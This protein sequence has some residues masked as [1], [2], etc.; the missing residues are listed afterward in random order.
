MLQQHSQY[1]RYSKEEKGAIE[2]LAKSNKDKEQEVID[3]LKQN[4]E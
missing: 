1:F 2:K 3:N 4:Y